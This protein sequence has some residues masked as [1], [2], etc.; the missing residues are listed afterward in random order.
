MNIV[1]V[2]LAAFVRYKPRVA[3]LNAPLHAGMITI[4]FVYVYLFVAVLQV[5]RID[6]GD[7]ARFPG[8]WP[9]NSSTW[10]S[11][12]REKRMPL[13][14]SALSRAAR[15]SWRVGIVFDNGANA[16]GVNSY[17]RNIVQRV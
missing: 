7:P 10:H 14:P 13:A 11:M 4:E 8:F 2:Y 5:E 1:V 3:E 15:L 6:P 9:Q 17:A 16:A 12:P